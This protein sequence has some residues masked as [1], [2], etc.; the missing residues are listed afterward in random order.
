[1]DERPKIIACEVLRDEIERVNP[2]Y[3]CEFFPGA[4]HDYPD[5]LR[6]APQERSSPSTARRRRRCWRG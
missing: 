2:G 5:K 6:A 1:M 3:E 4:L